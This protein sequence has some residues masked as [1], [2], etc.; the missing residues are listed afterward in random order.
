MDYEKIELTIEFQKREMDIR[1]S[2]ALTWLHLKQLLEDTLIRERL[3]LAPDSSF[4]LR[5]KNKNI[6]IE[7]NDIVAH[8]PIGDGDQLEIIEK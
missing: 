3:G 6:H 1:F 4:Q 2:K 5:V 7:E 8:Y